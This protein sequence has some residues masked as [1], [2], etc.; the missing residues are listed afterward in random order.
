MAPR[1]ALVTYRCE[2][3]GIASDSIDIQVRYFDDP[4]TD[5]EAYLQN[6]PTQ[7]YLNEK[8][9]LVTW[10][11]IAVMAIEDLDNLRNGKE[12]AGFISGCHDFVKWTRQ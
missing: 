3:A 5:I 7:S 9:E 1:I 4:A 8:G 12:I 6:E 2:V 10:P 11:L